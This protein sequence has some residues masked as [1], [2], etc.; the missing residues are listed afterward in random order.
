MFIDIRY[1]VQQFIWNFQFFIHKSF[2]NN[3]LSYPVESTIVNFDYR[4]SIYLIPK[5]QQ[6][7]M[8]K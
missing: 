5:T 7:L 6:I 1:N 3:R 4:L 2:N 8:V